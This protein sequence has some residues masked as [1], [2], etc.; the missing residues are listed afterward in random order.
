VGNNFQLNEV[1]QTKIENVFATKE[2]LKD[3]T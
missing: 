3:F 2:E 1:L